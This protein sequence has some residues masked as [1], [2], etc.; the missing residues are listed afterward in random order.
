[1]DLAPGLFIPDLL[2]DL[3][4][5]LLVLPPFSSAELR[6]LKLNLCLPRI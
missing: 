5:T 4:S 1:M 6:L 3:I 2:C